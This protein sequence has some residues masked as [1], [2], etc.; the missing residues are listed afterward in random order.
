MRNISSSTQVVVDKHTTSEGIKYEIRKLDS[1]SNGSYI[2]SFYVWAEDPTMNGGWRIEDEFNSLGEARKFVGKV[3][4]PPIKLT[5]PKKN[6]HGP[7]KGS[8]QKKGK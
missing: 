6:I 4:V 5:T 2:N 1:R 7:A 3:I 8:S